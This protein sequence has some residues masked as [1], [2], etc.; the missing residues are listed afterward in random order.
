VQKGESLTKAAKSNNEALLETGLF[1]ASDVT[2]PK[3]G[4]N[5]RI[6]EAGFGL[7]S[8][9]KYSP[10]VRGN[11]GI[12][13]LELK[14]RQAP[15]DT[16][17]NAMSDSLH[18][19]ALSQKQSLIYNEWYNQLRQKAKIEDFRDQYFTDIPATEGS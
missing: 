11:D 15:P 3:M 6:A 9:N 12:Y 8:A 7:T 4:E 13:L 10:P 18:F 1:L 16:V 2:I 5:P 17:F 14:D 19:E